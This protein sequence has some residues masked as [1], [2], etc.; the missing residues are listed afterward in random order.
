M[1]EGLPIASDIVNKAAL[2][3]VEGLI[4]PLL[5]GSGAMAKSV[6]SSPLNAL[7][8]GALSFQLPSINPADLLGAVMGEIKVEVS[9]DSLASFLPSLPTIPMPE[10]PKNPFADVP[11]PLAFLPAD[12]IADLGNPLDALFGTIS[13]LEAYLKRM[14]PAIPNPVDGLMGDF[15]KLATL[16]PTEV[17]LDITLPELPDLPSIPEIPNI[18]DILP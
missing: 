10:F 14:M 16:K 4:P 11:N 8:V 6:L 13:P 2:P 18:G 1:I 9:L 3:S 5:A 17:K 15:N 7:D 12:L